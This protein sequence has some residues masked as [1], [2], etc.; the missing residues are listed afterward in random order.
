MRNIIC[1]AFILTLAVFLV[2]CGDNDLDQEDVL[3]KMKENTDEVDSYHTVWDVTMEIEYLDTDQTEHSA[4]NMDIDAD[5][6]SNEL[7][8]KIKESDDENES[9]REYY[10]I[11][12][13]VYEN[14][15]DSGW[16][17]ESLKEI[18]V[19]NDLTLAYNKIATLVEEIEDELEMET[20]DDNYILTFN[21]SSK[22]VYDAQDEPYSVE[23]TGFDED[24][25]QQDMKIEIDKETLYIT[26]IENTITAKNDQNELKMELE[27]VFSDINEIEGI[28]LPEDID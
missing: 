21:G 17:K 15:N 14:D 1:S 3:E 26:H 18:D 27:Q 28:E 23:V 19:K 8:Q 20:D 11:G 5:E 25:V 7:R 13:S 12:D 10:M 6:S 2:A 22:K 16:S 24:G 4:L 9:V